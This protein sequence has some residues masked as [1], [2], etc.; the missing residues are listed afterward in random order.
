MRPDWLPGE[1]LV[2]LDELP[3]D[4]HSVP[5]IENGQLSLREF[6]VKNLEVHDWIELAPAPLPIFVLAFFDELLQ[7]AALLVYNSHE[8]KEFYIAEDITDYP[9]L[10]FALGGLTADVHVVDS[11]ND[12]VVNPRGL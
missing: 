4:I 5:L 6:S 10:V 2:E 11:G 1:S 7:V 9:S 3:G 8:A 12:L